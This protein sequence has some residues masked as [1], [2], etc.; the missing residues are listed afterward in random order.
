MLQVLIVSYETFRMHSSKF[1]HSGSCDLLICDEAH[2][3]KNDQTLTNRVSFS[4]VIFFFFF[5]FPMC[6]LI[7]LFM[8]FVHGFLFFPGSGIGCSG[9]QASHFIVRNSNAGERRV[10]MIHDMSHAIKFFLINS[11]FFIKKNNSCRMT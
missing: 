6:C 2:R 9:M 4:E 8:S 7:S 11:F 10:F 3:L 1:S 5:G